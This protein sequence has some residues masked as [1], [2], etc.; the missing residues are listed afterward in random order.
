MYKSGDIGRWLPDG[1]IEYLGRNDTQVKLRG[2]RI[3]LGEIEACL[4]AH[5]HVREAVVVARDIAQG[6]GLIGYV[7]GSDLDGLEARLRAHLELHLPEYMVPA[8]LV[9]LARLPLTLNGK[10]DRRALPE[11]EWS[12]KEYVA[13]GT[14]LERKLATIWQTVLEVPQPVGVT[15]NFFELGGD[16]FGAVKVLA[17]I[18]SQ[19]LGRLSVSSLFSAGT[20]RNLARRIEGEQASIP[21]I[22]TLKRGS[23]RAPIYCVP[24][25]YGKVG[26]YVDLA[27]GLPAGHGVI[28]LQARWLSDTQTLENSIEEIAAINARYIEESDQGAGC[29]IIGF[30]WGGIIAYE[31]ARRLASRVAVHFVG[32]I[33]V[34]HFSADYAGAEVFTEERRR[35]LHHRLLEWVGQSRLK[36][37]W[38]VLLERL[39]PQ[40]LDVCLHFL[41]E[42]MPLWQERHEEI[43]ESQEYIDII[44]ANQALMSAR[45]RLEPAPI[46]IR[47]WV[48]EL[49][50]RNTSRLID[51]K[52]YSPDVRNTV[53]AGLDHEELILS[54]V[55]CRGLA[56]QIMLHPPVELES[57]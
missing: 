24:P 2:F 30:S 47:S 51:W 13:P 39:P 10:L 38:T 41:E 35:E 36:H 17:L 32:M 54:D 42:R 31:M 43:S 25:F 16:S 23:G 1:T 26:G 52:R 18:R 20:I 22:V 21:N 56:A 4:L 46:V 57:A 55:L 29:F 28:G 3:E 48:S 37:L 7:T 34:H 19:K 45:Y 6:K 44:T 49:S 12:G 40:Q 15:D 50:L 8:R 27:N 14:D 5:P 53:L 33:D 9:V 11:P